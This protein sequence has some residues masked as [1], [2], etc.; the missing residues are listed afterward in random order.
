MCPVLNEKLD[1]LYRSPNTVRAIKS[2]R[3]I[4]RWAGHVARME[5]DR[6]SFKISTGKPTR[7][8]ILGRP[9]RRSDHNIRMVIEEIYISANNWVDSAKDRSYQRDLQ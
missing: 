4:V 6:S 2:R 8:K 5:E 3:L 9:R 1:S 7:K